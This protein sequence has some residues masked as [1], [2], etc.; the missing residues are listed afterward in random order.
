M[1]YFFSSYPHSAGVPLAPL[2]WELSNYC[3][4]TGKWKEFPQTVPATA[5]AANKIGQSHEVVV[6]NSS[7]LRPA[8]ACSI[9]AQQ[10]GG[11]HL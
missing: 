10:Q 8:A 2:L 4:C 9:A 6:F 1:P 11:S 7:L 5:T 3:Q